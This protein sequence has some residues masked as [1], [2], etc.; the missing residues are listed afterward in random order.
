MSRPYQDLHHETNHGIQN[1]LIGIDAQVSSYFLS[2]ENNTVNNADF[3]KKILKFLNDHNT[4]EQRIVSPSEAYYSL[5]NLKNLSR[6]RHHLIHSITY[7]LYNTT[8]EKQDINTL[9][10]EIYTYFHNVMNMRPIETASPYHTLPHE[11]LSAEAFS[12][13]D[14]RDLSRRPVHRDLSRRSVIASV[15]G[16]YFNPYHVFD[17]NQGN[18]AFC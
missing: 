10:T 8:D 13:A 4:L 9:K 17:I 18:Y 12:R 11:K 5:Y 14:H 2:N 15:T 6:E 1:I 7:K 16:S 3:L